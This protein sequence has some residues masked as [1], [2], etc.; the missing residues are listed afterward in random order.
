MTQPAPEIVRSIIALRRN[1]AVWRASGEGIGLVPTMGA[2]HDGHLA[3]I[4]AAAARHRRVAVTIFVNPTQFG[5][6]EDFS[7]YPRNE[8]DDVAKAAAAGAALIFAPAVEEMY[9]PG[10]ETAVNVGGLATVLEGASRPGHFDGVAT[11]VTKLLLQALPDSAYFG[12]KDYQQLLVIRRLVRDLDIPVAIAAVPTVREADGLALS[13]R[14]VY[15]SPEQRRIAPALSRVLATVADRVAG[16]AAVDE[17]LAWGEAQL[18]MAGFDAIDYFTVRDAESL[19]PVETTVRSARILAA[20][21]LGTTR[22]IDNVA[23]GGGQG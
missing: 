7:A 3:L 21:R 4:R 12:E 9:R 1:L 13:S 15:L 2:L 14:N 5:P 11:I 22:L 6:R 18:R 23:V 16:G 19:E 10:F 20:V 17:Q 8:A